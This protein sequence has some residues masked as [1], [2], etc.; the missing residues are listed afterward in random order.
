MGRVYRV[1]FENVTVSAAQD[2]ALIVGAAGKQLKIRKQWVS[3]TNT[4]LPTAQMLQFRGR[5]LPATV[6]NGS[7][8]AAAT[9]RPVDAGDAAAT[10]T[11]RVNDTTKATTSATAVV[12]E[13]NGGHIYNPY[14]CVFQAPPQVGPSQA[15]VF[16]LLSTVSG[17][18]AFSGGVEVEEIG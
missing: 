14:E 15:Y 2:L 10:F 13:Q 16:E 18:C 11:A 1:L 8:G 3:A 4:T 7:G 6:T 12:L 9:P 5:F 17:T